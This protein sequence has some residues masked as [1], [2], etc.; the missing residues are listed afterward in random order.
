MHWS[1]ELGQSGRWVLE[2][3]LEDLGALV[4]LVESSLAKFQGVWLPDQSLSVLDEGLFKLL[5]EFI[6]AS[7]A[8]A[9]VED[10]VGH[11]VESEVSEK[12][13]IH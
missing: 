12:A 8:P 3:P 9:E 10:D 6:R 2:H 13:L 5:N 1:L 4:D 7:S 11:L